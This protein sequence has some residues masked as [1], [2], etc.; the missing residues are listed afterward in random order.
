MK[1]NKLD[2]VQSLANYTPI[3]HRFLCCECHILSTAYVVHASL[4]SDAFYHSEE[5]VNISN[6]I[7]LYIM[8]PVVYIWVA[9]SRIYVRKT[10]S[11]ITGELFNVFSKLFLH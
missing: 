3:I 8:R 7:L 10:K 6:T 5:P 11:F 2:S 1:I 9:L 4:E